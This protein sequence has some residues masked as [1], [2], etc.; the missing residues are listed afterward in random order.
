ME[1]SLPTARSSLLGSTGQEKTHLLSRKNV[2]Q[3][4]KKKQM[5][6]T[7]TFERLF[8]GHG[9]ST[10]GSTTS[11]DSA[12]TIG[13]GSNNDTSASPSP[14]ASYVSPGSN[15][16]SSPSFFAGDNFDSDY[17]PPASNGDYGRPQQLGSENAQPY[18]AVVVSISEG[19]ATSSVEKYNRSL[20]GDF[21][22][23]E[24]AVPGSAKRLVGVVDE[25]RGRNDPD[26]NRFKGGQ[27]VE[28]DEDPRFHPDAPATKSVIFCVIPLFMGYACLFSLQHKITSVY[29]ITDSGPRFDQF[30]NAVSFLYVGNLVF[31]FAH[32]IVFACITPHV[33][34]IV[35]ITS[36]MLSL[37]L[38]LFGVFVFRQTQTLAWVYGAYALGGVAVGSFEAN[39]LSAITPLG[40]Q[41]KLWATL[42]IPIGVSSIT[43]GAFGVMAA[44]ASPEVIYGVTIAA[45]LCSLFVWS[46]VVPY[47]HIKGNSDSVSAFWG[48]LKDF[49]MWLPKIKWHAVCLAIDMAC[50]STFSPGVMLYVFD[51]PS[52]VP[53]L[54]NHGVRVNHNAFFCVYNL[55]TFCGETISRKVAY[56]DKKERSPWLFLLFS[57]VG[58][59]MN[60][61]GAIYGVGIICPLA[62]LFVFLANGSI[63]N[64]T[65]KYVDNHVDPVFNLTALSAWLFVG[66]LGSVLGSNMTPY[67]RQWLG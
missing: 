38:L 59:G 7:P 28:K 42:G 18:P 63:Y 67:V 62:G 43:I 24:P 47:Q 16:R 46:C 20:L 22:A 1:S 50:V 9:K 61:A 29:G 19:D 27:L 3:L 33:R 8:S 41:T 13:Y 66:D 49:R 35:A 5:I 36:M 57:L 21:D 37:S 17:A 65:T 23:T 2:D 14:I 53:L 39:V 56:V 52:G 64:R 26:D 4:T 60:V 55:F 32:N 15:G 45:L 11:H 12:S 54:G 44:G 30:G 6:S 51:D 58:I 34:V 40:H 48:S 31:R 25:S 10:P